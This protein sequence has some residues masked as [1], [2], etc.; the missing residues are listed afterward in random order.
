MIFY[1]ADLVQELRDGF[2]IFIQLNILT[3]IFPY[4]SGNPG[5]WE[6]ESKGLKNKSA[7]QSVNLGVGSEGIFKARPFVYS[8]LCRIIRKSWSFQ[9]KKSTYVDIRIFTPRQKF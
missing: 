2:K 4:I 8:P 6:I 1:K 7:K 9:N 3:K 5:F